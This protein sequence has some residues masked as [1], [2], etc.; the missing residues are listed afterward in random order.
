MLSEEQ[1]TGSIGICIDPAADHSRKPVYRGKLAFDMQ[2]LLERVLS[3]RSADGLSAEGLASHASRIV[4]SRGLANTSQWLS[5]GM[6]PP[7]RH[8]RGHFE[9]AIAVSGFS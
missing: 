5:V 8:K 4:S 9:I 6:V 3:P 7:L 2:D 1:R